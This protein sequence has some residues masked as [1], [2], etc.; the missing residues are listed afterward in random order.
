MCLS[1][2]QRA[3]NSTDHSRSHKITVWLSFSY[4]SLILL[5]YS[6]DSFCILL[7]TYHL[8]IFHSNL[9]SLSDS[10]SSFIFFFFISAAV[11]VVT[12]SFWLLS[13]LPQYPFY[14]LCLLPSSLPLP[15]LLSSLPLSLYTLP[16]LL[17]FVL[18]QFLPH[19]QTP[20]LLPLLHWAHRSFLPSFP[21][22]LHFCCFFT[23]LWCRI[24]PPPGLQPVFW[25]RE[26][27]AQWLRWAEK[28]FALRPI[29]SGSFQMNGKALLLLTKEDFRYRSPHSGTRLLSTSTFLGDI[30]CVC[31]AGET[32]V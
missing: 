10:V 9:L 30:R 21:L 24:L 16:S 29:T 27:V 2:V 25:S 26:D 19:P 14:C 22:H 8:L 18:S 31:Q 12:P 15:L 5:F 17:P 11:P 1:G 20:L 3:K 23:K 7:L 6:C 4:N 28:E 32:G 13:P